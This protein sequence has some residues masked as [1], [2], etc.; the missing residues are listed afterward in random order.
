MRVLH[1]GE[2]VQG[3]VATYIATLLNHSKNLEIE[4]FLICSEK[5]SEYE[6][7]IPVDHVNYYPYERSLLRIFPA[8]VAIQ[9]EIRRVRPDVI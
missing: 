3:G 7:N 1:I 5:N 6:W 8:M 2:Y 4:D 9:K